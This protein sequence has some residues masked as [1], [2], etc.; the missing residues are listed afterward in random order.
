MEVYARM[1]GV[2]ENVAHDLDVLV[3]TSLYVHLKTAKHHS[4]KSGI[5][6]VLVHVHSRSWCRVET[7]APVL[8]PPI[9]SKYWHGNGLPT[10]DKI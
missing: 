4:N 6:S 5:L 10:L 3:N 2:A 1:P 8:V 7:H 9:M